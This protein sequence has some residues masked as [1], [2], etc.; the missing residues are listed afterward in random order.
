MDAR[1][2][3]VDTRCARICVTDDE[4]GALLQHVYEFCW[5]VAVGSGKSADLILHHEPPLLMMRWAILKINEWLAYLSLDLIYD[6][7]G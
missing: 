6:L 1:D 2:S 7:Q 4:F 3:L 5:R